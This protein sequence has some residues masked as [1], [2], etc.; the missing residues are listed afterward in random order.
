MS[1][2]YPVEITEEEINLILSSIEGAPAGGYESIAKN[3][4]IYTTAFKRLANIL[5]EKLLNM[6]KGVEAAE[7]AAGNSEQSAKVAEE[8]AK[9]AEESAEFAARYADEAAMNATISVE[10]AGEAKAIAENAKNTAE[11]IHSVADA[12]LE[13]AADV[14]ANARDIAREEIAKYDFIKVVSAL[15]AE[16]MPNRIY[17]IPKTE[18]DISDL[19][20]M[21]LWVNKG[22]ED[23]PSYVWEFEGVKTCEIDLTDYVKNT[24][25][26][27]STK[28]GVVQ[29]G[30]GLLID[31]NKLSVNYAMEGDVDNRR[32]NAY[33][34]A[35]IVDYAVKHGLAYKSN[36]EVW[37]PQEQDRAKLTIGAA[38]PTV[39]TFVFNEGDRL[40]IALNPLFF[41]GIYRIEWGDGSYNRVTDNTNVLLSHTYPSIGAYYCKLYG[42]SSIKDGSSTVGAA[43]YLNKALTS[44]KMSDSI[45]SLGNY[46]FRG[47]TNLAKI[48]LSNS[49]KTIGVSAFYLCSALKHLVIP[50]TV[51]SIGN[52]AFYRTG[53]KL[54]EFKRLTPITATREWFGDNDALPKFVVP[55]EALALYRT[56]WTVFKTEYAGQEGIDSV[57]YNG[58]LT[59]K[60]K[61]T[62]WITKTIIKRNGY[63]QIYSDDADL[64]LCKSDGTV[65]VENVK[66]FQFIAT[67]IHNT[68]DN[69]K[70]KACGVYWTGG[71]LSGVDGFRYT[72]DDGSYVMTTGSSSY[73]VASMVREDFYESND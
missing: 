64:K 9:V 25:Y 33:I 43:F 38:T 16:G 50:E 2:K 62:S 35:D 3:K 37:T 20:E 59:F 68:S 65:L 73:Y 15:P 7:L 55:A 67:P 70:F 17:L 30:D 71:V 42:V 72:L 61:T 54:L 4:S 47:C 44:I 53:L 6:V 5:A 58:N 26:A 46:T 60:Y 11:D 1:E 31:S 39:L 28:A 22:T 14:E 10:T 24:D 27:T 52:N 21:W 56:E 45:T 8:S 66:Q 12:A 51:E 36:D 32:A 63:Y 40:T 48:E 18:G 49:L 19:F 29:V 23:A 41:T 57:A 13:K 34:G 69:S